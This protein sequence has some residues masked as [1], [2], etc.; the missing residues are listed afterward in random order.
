MLEEPINEFK[1]AV[2]K[3]DIYSIRS[4]LSDGIDINETDSEG[5]TPL[6]IASAIAHTEMVKL[7]LAHGANINDKNHSGWTPLIYAVITDNL[8]IVE[9]LVENG[10]DLTKRD[11]D[12]G[13]NAFEWAVSENL[14]SIIRFLSE[15]G[16]KVNCSQKI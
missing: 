12:F 5:K 6:M 1:S 14:V 7:L 13:Y 8:E 9:L 2:W 15:K 10:A 3:G 16:S 4:L 11:F